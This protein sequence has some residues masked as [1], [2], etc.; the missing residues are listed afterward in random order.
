M[1]TTVA[2]LSAD[3]FAIDTSLC[4][5]VSP[6]AG[7]YGEVHQASSSILQSHG[8][9]PCPGWLM[10]T[11]LSVLGTNLLLNTTTDATIG[12]RTS[13]IEVGTTNTVV[14]GLVATSLR[15]EHLRNLMRTAASLAL[16]SWHSPLMMNNSLTILMTLT[17]FQSNSAFHGS[18][19]KIICSATLQHTLGLIGTY[20]HYR[21]HLAHQKMRTIYSQLWT[22]KCS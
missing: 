20:P 15:M 6:S 7:T 17:K 21:C 13:R 11:Y 3:T 4:F 14:F 12:V 1:A 18:F 5:R 8:I 2:H 22:G 10:T 9:G 16:T 19:P